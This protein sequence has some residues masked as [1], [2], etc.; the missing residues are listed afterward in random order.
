VVVC[1]GGEGGDHR[2]TASSTRHSSDSNVAVVSGNS[3]PALQPVV[4]HTIALAIA[5]VSQ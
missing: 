4:L 3:S 5:P 2:Y 1:G